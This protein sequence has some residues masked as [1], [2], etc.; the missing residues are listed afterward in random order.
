[1][2]LLTGRPRVKVSVLLIFK[3]IGTDDSLWRNC[4]PNCNFWCFDLDLLTCL[5]KYEPRLKWEYCS[6]F[7][8][9]LI[10]QSCF[11]F[12]SFTKIC[13]KN[14]MI[15]QA[16]VEN[17]GSS[18]VSVVNVDLRRPGGF[19]LSVELVI[20]NFLT[21]DLITHSLGYWFK[22]CN[23]YSHRKKHCT[24]VWH[25]CLGRKA[26]CSKLLYDFSRTYPH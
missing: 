15:W 22:S 18:N 7:D 24:T 13:L 1:M 5:F 3:E 2:C 20:S 23:L 12:R 8:P 6:K 26:R 16:Q 4:R 9:T 21:H 25:F 19:L 14:D 10:G 11:N 17:P